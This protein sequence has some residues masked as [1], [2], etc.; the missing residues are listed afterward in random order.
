MNEWHKIWNR[1]TGEINLEDDIFSVYRSL[2]IANGFDVNAEEGYY[3]SFFQDFNDKRKIIHDKIG[4]FTSLYEVGCGSGVNLFLFNKLDNISRLGGCDY[5]QSLTKLAQQVAGESFVKNMDA[6]DIDISD[7][8]DV[9]LADSVFQYF[10][11]AQ[12]GYKVLDLMRRKADKMV[13]VTEVHDESLKQEHLD[14]RK[15]V[16]ENYDEVY[17]GLD[18][19]FYSKEKLL[20]YADSLGDEYK[21]EIVKPRNDKYW[22][23]RFVFDFYLWKQ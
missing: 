1:K 3:E 23:N 19:T 4:D 17:K 6:E 21:C 22:N 18:K 15:S 12:K 8:Y 10:T 13:V 9:V 11:S 2:K 5:S 16:I 14:Y 20:A 7:K